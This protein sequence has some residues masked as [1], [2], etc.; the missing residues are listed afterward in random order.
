[1]FPLTLKNGSGH[2]GARCSGLQRPGSVAHRSGRA[3]RPLRRGRPGDISPGL[4]KEL[5]HRRRVTSSVTARQQT[6]RTSAGK[7][8]TGA[9]PAPDRAASLP[10]QPRRPSPRVRAGSL[11]TFYRLLTAPASDVSAQIASI[12]A[13][14]A[15]AGF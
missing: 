3:G 14:Y 11:E 8:G 1:M 10:V 7:Q 4:H 15:T 2:P 9:G 5:G 12:P 6:L 13:S